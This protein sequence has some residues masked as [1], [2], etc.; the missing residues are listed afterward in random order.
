MNEPALNPDM[1]DQMQVRLEQSNQIFKLPK[2][3]ISPILS[4]GSQYT[5]NEAETEYRSMI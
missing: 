3:T 2:A 5:N 1:T 4:E